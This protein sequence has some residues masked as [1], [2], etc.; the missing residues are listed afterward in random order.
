MWWNEWHAKDLELFTSEKRLYTFVCEF[1]CIGQKH[2]I[3]DKIA[4]VNEALIEFLLFLFSY[5]EKLYVNKFSTKPKVQ[6]RILSRI[7]KKEFLEF[8]NDQATAS[9]LLECKVNSHRIEDYKNF[10]VWSDF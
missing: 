2:K 5:I 6:R 4:S 7:F 8:F 10:L 3:A 1:I 9:S